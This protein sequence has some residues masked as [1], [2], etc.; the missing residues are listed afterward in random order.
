[1]IVHHEFDMPSSIRGNT[2]SLPCKVITVLKCDG[3]RVLSWLV[4]VQLRWLLAPPWLM[5]L[6]PKSGKHGAILKYSLDSSVVSQ[7]GMP[8]LRKHPERQLGNVQK[9]FSACVRIE[10]ALSFIVLSPSDAKL[11]TQ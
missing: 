10:Q 1:M 2:P 3:V 9:T 6:G 5:R 8:G 4:Q 7:M 11:H